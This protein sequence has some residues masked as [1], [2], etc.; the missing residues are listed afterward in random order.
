[1]AKLGGIKDSLSF[2]VLKILSRFG[3]KI[4]KCV[5]FLQ[6]EGCVWGVGVG[7][8]ILNWPLG[9]ASDPRLADE[10]CRVPQG[11]NSGGG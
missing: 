4:L 3:S 1:M 9:V 7:G 6:N 8:A 2:A 11:M 10:D 5:S